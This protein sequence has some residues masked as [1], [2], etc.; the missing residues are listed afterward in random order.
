MAKELKVGDKINTKNLSYSGFYIKKGSTVELAVY[1]NGDEEPR[2]IVTATLTS[3]LDIDDDYK[4]K[5]QITD[6]RDED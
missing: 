6:I 1:A 3:D 5:I 4:M 2:K